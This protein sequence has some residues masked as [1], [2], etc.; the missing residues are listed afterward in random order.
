MLN[1]MNEDVL[2]LSQIGLAELMD[3]YFNIVGT[4]LEILK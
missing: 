4:Y 2:N 3:E 1:N